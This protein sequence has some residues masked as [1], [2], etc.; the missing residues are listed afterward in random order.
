MK[1][2]AGDGPSLACMDKPWEPQG[3]GHYLGPRRSMPGQECNPSE[4]RRGAFLREQD[5]TA[6]AFEP[7]PSP[8]ALN[9]E[10]KNESCFAG[11]TGA[12]V[13][14][15]QNELTV[16]WRLPCRKQAEGQGAALTLL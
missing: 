13:G 11:G 4:V 6:T 15:R 7:S 8:P 12:V 3:E 10:G 9:K 2:P 14:P 16:G 1:D 5:S